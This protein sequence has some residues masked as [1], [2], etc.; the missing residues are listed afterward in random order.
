LK[1]GDKLIIRGQARLLDG[2]RVTVN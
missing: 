2:M 1:E